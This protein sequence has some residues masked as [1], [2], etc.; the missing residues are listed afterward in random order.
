V[1]ERRHAHCRFRCCRLTRPVKASS[2]EITFVTKVVW[3]SGGQSVRVASRTTA[4]AGVV[5]PIRYA[6]RITRR[7]FTQSAGLS[8]LLELLGKDRIRDRRWIPWQRSLGGR[9]IQIP[10]YDMNM[11][12]R[13]DVAKQQVVHVTR[14]EDTL[15]HHPN[16]L[17]VLG[18]VGKLAGGKIGEV[19]DVSATKDDGHVA[20]RDGVPFKDRLADAAAVERSGGQ[21]AAEVTRF[22]ALACFPV[23]RPGSS[24]RSV[25]RARTER[26]SA[27]LYRASA[28]QSSVPSVDVGSVERDTVANDVFPDLH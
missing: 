20:V 16:V 4:F 13:H 18:V 1:A 14:P 28:M 19:G 12:V 22:A 24:H 2:S 8:Q 17:D 5:M 15:D 23:I 11:E 25:S 9:V 27:P 26:R 21:I 6:S 10:R 3:Q 7:S